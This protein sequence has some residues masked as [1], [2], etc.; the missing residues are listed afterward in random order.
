ML[1][2]YRLKY[3]VYKKALTTLQQLTNDS[4]KAKADRDYYQF[5]VDELE[6]ASLMVGEQELLEAE[7]FTLN[8]AEEIKRNLSCR[9]LSDAGWRNFGHYS[10]ARSG[11]SSFVV[12]KVQSPKSQSCINA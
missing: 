3:K 12:G 9:Q 4:D 7:L 10:V 11:S 2:E 5:Q 8:N 6:K 1:A